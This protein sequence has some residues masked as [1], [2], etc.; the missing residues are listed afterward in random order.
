MKVF[1]QIINSPEDGK[2][3]QLTK[4]ENYLGRMT[5]NEI[6]LLY[7]NQISRRHAKIKI[8]NQE[9]W[10]EDM[11]SRNGTFV[12]NERLEEPYLLSPEE[13]FRVGKTYLQVIIN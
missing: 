13:T 7:D 10:V 9:I 8:D 3:Y 1:L 12:N 6:V 4:K 2:E 11:D 5:G